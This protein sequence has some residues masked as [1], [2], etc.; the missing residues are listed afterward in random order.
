MDQ[1]ELEKVAERVRKLLRLA[2]RR[3]GNEAEAASA[4]A[5]AQEI[6]LAHNLTASAVEEGGASSGKREDA[7]VRGGAREYEREMWRAVAELNFCFYFAARTRTVKTAGLKTL[8]GEVVRPATYKLSFFHRLVG[9][10]ENVAATRATADYLAGAIER[11][12]RARLG[13]DG[14]RA[15]TQLWGDW[16]LSF[17][18]GAADQIIE[19]LQE[20]RAHRVRKEKREAEK[21]EKAAR[22]AA[23]GSVSSGTALTVAALT[24]NEEQANY[25]FLHGEG[26]WAKKEAREAEN[27]RS[28]AEGRAHRARLAAEAD[29]AHAA[30]A[31]ANP[32]EAAAEAARAAA[33]ARRRARNA[34]RRSGPRDRAPTPQEQRRWSGGYRA[35]REAGEGVGIEPQAEKRDVKRI[36]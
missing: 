30:W 13:D 28:W 18:E 21:R 1:V 12:L 36:G 22:E 17:R 26:A 7:R 9:R 31:E 27:E 14:E 20:R 15:G 23:A 29:A 10:V 11:I 34:A 8:A 16:A 6:L 32:E 19:R 24:R 2:E 35:G 25:D 5:K 33:E 3:G 4:A